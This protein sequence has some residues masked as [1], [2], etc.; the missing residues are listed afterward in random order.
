[1]TRVTPAPARLLGAALLLLAF[2]APATAS[3][4]SLRLN[5]QCYTRNQPV[6]F[7]GAGF[8]PNQV[9]T[10]SVGGT[11]LGTVTSNGSGSIAGRFPAPAP[12]PRVTSV[13]TYTMRASASGTTARTRFSVVHTNIGVTPPLITPGFV[14]YRAL[15]FT[16]SRSLY[17]HYLRS[18]RHLATRRI[19]S[20]S[21]PCGTLTKKVRMFL[22]RPVRPATYT[23]VFD[24]SSRYSSSYRPNFSFQAVVPFTFN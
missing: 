8:Q 15:G 20:L 9:E 3:A 18:G 19:G 1:L 2:A 17:V 24:N 10:I 5:R 14:T 4:A 21:A 7:T 23:L 11:V 16:Y 13:R 22:F 12:F 6:R